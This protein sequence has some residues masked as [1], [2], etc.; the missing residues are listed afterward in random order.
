MIP[1]A[2]FKFLT[3][4]ICSVN[5]PARMNFEFDSLTLYMASKKDCQTA[6]RAAAECKMVQVHHQ[7]RHTH[8]KYPLEQRQKVHEIP[9]LQ[10]VYQQQ[11]IVKMSPNYDEHYM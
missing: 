1:P 4:P 8:L 3:I 10:T 2:P 11:S 5:F 9:F 6:Q 7:G